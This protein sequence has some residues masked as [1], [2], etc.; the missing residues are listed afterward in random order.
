M[1]NVHILIVDDHKVVR[2]G[3]KFMLE[4][5][6]Y[7]KS[8]IEETDTEAGAVQ[9][10]QV[11]DYD[12]VLMDINIR[13]GSGLAA[14]QKILSFNEETKIIA[15]SMFDDETNIHNMIKAG[16]SGYV[17]KNAGEDELVKAIR[18]VLAGDNY[19]S[20][21]VAQTLLNIQNRK[22]INIGSKGGRL[23]ITRREKEVITLITEE[24]TNDEIATKLD[25][26]RRTVEG[27]RKNILLKLGLKNT[28]GLVR[29]AVE[30]SLV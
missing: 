28:A 16:V 14:T 3:L 20:N 1:E 25:I 30:N 29:F 18:T 17:L 22:K 13:E 2:E 27:H 15:L 6:E 5:T 9:R 26:S 10:C 24:F 19:Y 8:L 21:E 23:T 4:D 12:I 7:F 11:F